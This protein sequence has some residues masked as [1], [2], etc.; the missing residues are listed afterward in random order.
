M[1]SRDQVGTLAVRC[2]CWLR[3]GSR[4]KS[5]VGDAERYEGCCGFGCE[6]VSR[7]RIVAER[8]RLPR[9]AIEA[10]NRIE[11]IPMTNW[12][13]LKGMREE[14]GEGGVPR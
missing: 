10:D 13:I 12:E 3:R 11:F 1:A 5:S 4:D 7:W 6:M 2:T 9:R 8:R 14:R